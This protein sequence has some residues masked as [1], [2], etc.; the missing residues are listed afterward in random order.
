M[1][2]AATVTAQLILDASKF[3]SG[4]KGATKDAETFENRMKAVGATMTKIGTAMTAAITVPLAIIGKQAIEMASNYEESLNKVNVVFENSSDVIEKWAKD[5]AKNLG[6]SQQAA[7]EAAATYGNL[8]TAQGMGVDQ[9]AEMSVAL[10]N[11]SA[12]LASFNNANP[13][14][15]LL[16]LRSG[17]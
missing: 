8:F 9:A 4:M 3:S 17:L 6:L 14:D 1:T 10:V 12:D 2:T 7:L 11:L 13:E 5:A 16:A 15:V